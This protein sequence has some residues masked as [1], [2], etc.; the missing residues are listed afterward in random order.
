MYTK[1]IT[2]QTSDGP[3]KGLIYKL[4]QSY[5]IN[6][7]LRL[8]ASKFTPLKNHTFDNV[9][10]W[11]DDWQII[12]RDKPTFLTYSFQ[13]V[14]IKIDHFSY[15]SASEWCFSKRNALY[16]ANIKSNILLQA[17]TFTDL[18]GSSSLCQ[19]TKSKFFSVTDTSTIFTSFTF[20]SYDSSCDTNG[21]HF[22]GSG[23]DFF[24]TMY[25]ITLCTKSRFINLF[26]SFTFLYIFAFC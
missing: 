10:N 22:S 16:G 19:S 2:A 20:I 8:S 25:K 14:A 24:G 18:C 12:E 7:Y 4:K 1:M 6:K 5:D 15:Q 17:P 13:N 3:S 9:L 11:G 23:I 21:V 26:H